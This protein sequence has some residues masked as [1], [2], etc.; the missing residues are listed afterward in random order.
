[1][2]TSN[3]IYWFALAALVLVCTPGPNMVYCLS[4]TL[5]Q[6][7]SAG[8][9]SLAGVLAAYGVH[10]LATALGLTA[11]LVNSPA[12]IEAIKRSGAGC[13]LW[14]A[15]RMLRPRGAAAEASRSLQ[16]APTLALF[17]MGF[18]INLLNPNALLFYLALLPQFL[19]PDQGALMTQSLQLGA[20]QVAINAAVMG[21]LVCAVSRL[22]PGQS[23]QGKAWQ[24]ARR[25]LLG[26]VFAAMAAW[27]LLARL[28]GL[29]GLA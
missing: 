14:M 25:Y 28:S 8:L 18:V 10:L 2:Q 16:P 26:G 12:A 6:G 3:N 9:I 15:W 11:L 17:G 29:A 27:L 22:Q 13:R 5:C 23:A 24:G 7:R 4:R 20:V 1:M 21:L 19:R